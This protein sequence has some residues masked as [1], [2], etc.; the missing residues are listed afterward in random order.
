MNVSRRSFIKSS[1][2]AVSAATMPGV[3]FLDFLFDQSNYQMTPL[4]NDV[5]V[6]SERGGTIGWMISKDG[7]VVVDTQFPTQAGHLIEEIQKKSDKKIDLL[8]NT[9]HHGD[10]SAG[11]IAF[12]GLV[13]KVVAHENSKNNQK[14]VAERRNSLET[15]LFPDTTYTSG[16]WSGRVGS[17]TVTLHYFGAGHTNG[18]SI[19]H[20]ENANIAHMGDLLFNRRVPY[21]DKSAGANITN[22]QVILETAYQTFDDDTVFVFGHAGDGYKITGKRN[23]LQA[24]KNYLEKVMVFV[25]KGIAQG[26]TKEAMAQAT[27]IPGAEEWKGSQKRAVDA[28]YLEIIEGK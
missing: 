23:D 14:K 8:V 17:E 19:V 26:K 7:L 5:G 3:H 28:A 20:F 13:N 10:H 21:I 4:R 12:K 15:Q 16:K 22:W 18:D 11:N 24:F 2:L 9:H 27:S 1:G 6:F 25:K